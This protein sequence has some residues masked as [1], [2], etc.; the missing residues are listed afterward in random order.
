MP[1][2]PP[3]GLRRGKRRLCIRGAGTKSEQALTN[4]IGAPRAGPKR[5]RPPLLLRRNNNA[6]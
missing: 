6:G 5:C 2:L 3:H 4:C 1:T